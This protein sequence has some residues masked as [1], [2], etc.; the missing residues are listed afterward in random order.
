MPAR[1]SYN[2][3]CGVARAL[4]LVGERWTLLIVR[5]LILGPLRYSDLL[6]G[7]PGITTNLLAGRLK[8]LENSGLIERV[9]ASGTDS[10]HLYRLT[11][12]GAG[13][14][15]AINALGA[16]GWQRLQPPGRKEYRSIDFLLTALR[17]RYLG[18]LTLRAEI[19]A[20]DMPFRIEATKSK[21]EV[22]RGVL[23][24][25][26]LRVRG[27]SAVIA[28]LF[29]DPRSRSVLPKGIDV[30][31]STKSLDALLK[32]FSTEELNLQPEASDE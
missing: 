7:L 16:W 31:G 21:A 32:A 5:N 2:Q 30:E 13:L 19:V 9:R 1:R 23:R 24:S 18:G 10:G 14:E 3:Y 26:D 8:E 12:L 25:P 29:L 6:R 20:D 15:P 11:E 27:S 22:T 17:R 28:N 4:D